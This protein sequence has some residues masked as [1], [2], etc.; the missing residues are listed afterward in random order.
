MIHKL[1]GSLRKCWK[2]YRIAKPQGDVNKL[3]YYAKRIQK[4]E[5]KLRIEL[6]QFPQLGIYALGDNEGNDLIM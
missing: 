6:T 5:R 3:I 2:G 1:W 4:F